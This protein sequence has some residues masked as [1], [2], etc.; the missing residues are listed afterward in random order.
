MSPYVSPAK[1]VLSKCDRYATGT[2][3]QAVTTGGLLAQEVNNAIRSSG[4]KRIT[5][6]I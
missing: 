2:F 4:V 3:E 5:F 6:A 1:T